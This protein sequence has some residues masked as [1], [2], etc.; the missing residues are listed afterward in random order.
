VF[1]LSL[2]KISEKRNLDL[3]LYVVLFENLRS[4]LRRGEEEEDFGVKIF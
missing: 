2:F 3:G 4:D 1:F